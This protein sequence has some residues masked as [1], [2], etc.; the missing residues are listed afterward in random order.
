MKDVKERR[1]IAR[2]IV[3]PLLKGKRDRTVATIY[4]RVTPGADGRS[5]TACAPTA[6][7]TFR[8]NSKES[9]I[10]SASTNWQNQPKKV[11]KLDPLYH[12]R[13]IVIP[14]EGMILVAGDY[15]GAEAVMV[16]AYSEDWPFLDKLLAGKDIHTEHARH[17]FDTETP[18]PLQRDI[19]KTLTYLSFY[20]GSAFTATERM[21]KDADTTGVYVTV[22][23]VTRLRAIL[24]QLHTLERWWANTRLLLD[25]TNGVLRNCFGFRRVFRD[26]NPDYRLKDG[27]AFY[28]QSSIAWLINA[29]I[30]DLEHR[31]FPGEVLLQIHDELL[32]QT[33][34]DD[35]PELI[36]TLTPLYERPFTVQGRELYVPVEWKSGP[37]WGHLS[38]VAPAQ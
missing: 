9:N 3:E 28:P 37:D 26:P 14:D 12:V 38:P 17:F 11:A 19:A 8:L 34:P 7:T 13:D 23:E 20:Y 32:F 10:F 35:V 29:V 36:Y 24:L 33:R 22:E 15:K 2:S 5:H 31:S 16:A 30:A 1:A 27:L 21:N 25:K 6:T 4:E 18:T